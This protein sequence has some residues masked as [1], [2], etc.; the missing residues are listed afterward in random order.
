MSQSAVLE[1]LI[2]KTFDIYCKVGE[3]AYRDHYLHLWPGEDPAPYINSSFTKEILNSETSE[4]NTF[5]FL[6]KSGIEVIGILKLIV[7]EDI[8]KIPLPRPMYLEK[9]YLLR[10]HTGKGYG[11]QVLLQVEK[12]AKEHSAKSIWLATMKKGFPLRFYQNIGFEIIGEQQ[13][14][15]EKSIP[16]ERGMYLLCKRLKV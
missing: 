15:F 6:V 12:L 8:P 13:L 7:G 4:K 5:H 11:K 14:P 1:P 9:I 16:E 2:K 10:K 3:Q